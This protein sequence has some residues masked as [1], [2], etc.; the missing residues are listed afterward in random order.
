MNAIEVKNLEKSYGDFTLSIENFL[1]PRGTIMGLIGENGAGKTTFIKCLLKMLN[2]KGQITVLG[3]SLDKNVKEKMAVI[4]DDSY[5]PDQM[6]PNEIGKVLNKIYKNYDLNYYYELLEKFKI[7]K[8]KKLREFSKGMFVKTKIAS[9][10]SSRPEL[11][12]LDEPT[13]GLDP[14]IRSEILDIFY[15]FIE[16]ERHSIL[17]SSHI[18]SDLEKIADYITLIDNGKIV[19][20]SSIIDLKDNYGLA[21]IKPDEFDKID[22]KYLLKYIKNKY[23]YKALIKNKVEFKNSYPNT[24][25]ESLNI[26]ELMV[27]FIKGE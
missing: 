16:D 17:I 14:V 7:P 22:K 18:T 13:T 27:F 19:F 11:L 2:Y 9:S 3:K 20:K 12:I 23:N 10:L 1:L 8:N 24:D 26:E 6:T 5:F 25:V 21:I 4:L 15:N